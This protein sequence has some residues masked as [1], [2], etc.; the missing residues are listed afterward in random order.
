MATA[1]FMEGVE[2]GGFG[3]IWSEER[4]QRERR[5]RQRGRERR[6]LKGLLP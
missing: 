4:D 5:K 2:V 3:V 6:G 1:N